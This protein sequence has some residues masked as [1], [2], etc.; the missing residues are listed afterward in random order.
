MSAC[1]INRKRATPKQLAEHLNTSVPTALSL[2]HRGVIPAVVAEGR[3][4]RFDLDE[5]DSVLESRAKRKGG[6]A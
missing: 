6:A 5:V 4:Y 3:V 2:Y 1:T